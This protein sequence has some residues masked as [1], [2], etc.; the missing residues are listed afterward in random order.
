MEPISKH[1]SEKTQIE[2]P[3][4]SALFKCP[5]CISKDVQITALVKEISYLRPRELLVF[6]KNTKFYRASNV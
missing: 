4:C 6:K 3:N 5:N 2:C 1:D